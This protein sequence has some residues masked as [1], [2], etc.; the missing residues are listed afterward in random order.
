MEEEFADIDAVTALSY[1]AETLKVLVL[2][3]A[4]LSAESARHID[5][6]DENEHKEFLGSWGESI[7][8]GYMVWV[9]DEEPI[10]GTPAEVM[11]AIVIAKYLKCR[12][13]IYDQDGQTLAA[14]S[15]RGFHYDW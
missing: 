6:L 14:L 3:T 15:R 13:I 5:E 2:S 4:H 7:R 8:Y 12:R 10:N 11:A 9:P 1:A